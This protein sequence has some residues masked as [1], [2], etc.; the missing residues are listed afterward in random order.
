MISLKKGLIKINWNEVDKLSTEDITYF[1]SLEG[2]SVEAISKIR[3][4]DKEEIKRH[5]IEGKIKYRFLAKSEDAG[6]LFETLCNLGKQDKLS[7][8]MALNEEN[9]A[10]LALYIRNNYAS[11]LTK[12]KET[13]IWILG[14]L[15][16]A[17]NLDILQKAIVH[18]HVNIRRMAA[19]AMGKIADKASEIPLIRTLDDENPQVVLYA[20]KSLTKIKS[21]KAMD[22]IKLICES[23]DKEY[24]K[25][26]AEEYINS[27]NKSI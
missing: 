5:I 13:A 24:L 26:G 6:Q 19:S 21:E 23:T 14:E 17:D 2:K 9:K 25:R 22:K 10:R 3:N 16:S 7:S 4:L 1:L 20:I 11:M 18:N 8:L 27:F 12:Q 15:K